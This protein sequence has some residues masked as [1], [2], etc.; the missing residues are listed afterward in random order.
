MEI[1]IKVTSS[2]VIEYCVDKSKV[3]PN[4]NIAYIK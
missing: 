2:I 4:N 1:H 3:I